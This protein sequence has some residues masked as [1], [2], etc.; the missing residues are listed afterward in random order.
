MRQIRI[1]LKNINGKEKENR[2][3][4][5]RNNVQADETSEYEEETTCLYC[6][7]LYANLIE[8]CCSCSNRKQLLK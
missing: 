2:R 1:K 8:G 7:E 6:R 5:K 4:F 3:K